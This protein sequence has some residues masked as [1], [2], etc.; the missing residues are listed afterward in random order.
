MKVGEEEEGRKRGENRWMHCHGGGDRRRGD[1]QGKKEKQKTKKA[2]RTDH[3][4]RCIDGRC[5]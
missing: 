5:L 4:C 3:I 2:M 1:G